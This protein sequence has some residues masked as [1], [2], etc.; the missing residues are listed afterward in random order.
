[1]TALT[2]IMLCSLKQKDK[3]GKLAAGLRKHTGEDSFQFRDLLSGAMVRRSQRRQIRRRGR[4][5]PEA[6]G[7]AWNTSFDKVLRDYIRET[8]GVDRIDTTLTNAVGH[9]VIRQGKL[10]QARMTSQSAEDW[11]TSKGNYE[12]RCNRIAA[13]WSSD[14]SPYRA[15]SFDPRLA[16]AHR[17]ERRRVR[18]V[19]GV[20]ELSDADLVRDYD[21]FVSTL[22]YSRRQIHV[23]RLPEGVFIMLDGVKMSV[24]EAFVA[25]GAAV[26]AAPNPEE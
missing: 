3:I 17:R 8:L 21:Q 19:A 10:H 25:I 7:M 2:G 1:L 16:I 18:T 11:M 9:E 20:V 23:R 5:P 22:V 14:P 15:W 13:S 4:V 12:D 26:Y 24:A 6:G